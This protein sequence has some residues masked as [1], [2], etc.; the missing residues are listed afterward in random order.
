LAEGL[1]LLAERAKNAAEVDEIA[2]GAGARLLPRPRA[3]PLRG[4][5]AD[6]PLEV[7]PAIAFLDARLPVMSTRSRDPRPLALRLMALRLPAQLVVPDLI[8]TVEW[9]G[10]L[11]ERGRSKE[12]GDRGNGGAAHGRLP[13]SPRLII[14]DKDTAKVLP[15]YSE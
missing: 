6:A 8:E 5:I 1:R 10:R 12:D 15:M 2:T 3:A 7:G 4:R 11:S 14:N 13:F 9:V